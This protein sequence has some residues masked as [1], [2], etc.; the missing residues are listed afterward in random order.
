[1]SM[2]RTIFAVSAALVLTA[3]LGAQGVAQ[4]RSADMM[5]RTASA[6]TATAAYATG[7]NNSITVSW[8]SPTITADDTLVG[9]TI[10]SSPNTIGAGG[11][12]SR[13]IDDSTIRSF[14]FA[15]DSLTLGES[16]TF[17]VEPR[18]ENFPTA[19]QGPLSA[20]T[21]PLP[22]FQAPVRPTIGTAEAGNAAVNVRWTALADADDSL[23]GLPFARYT[24]TSIPGG[25]SCTTTVRTDD[26]C[27]VTG[28]TNGTS[29]TF[30]V[31]A[32]NTG[33]TSAPSLASAPV[34]PVATGRPSPPLNVV[35]SPGFEQASVSW[36]APSSQGT[37]G[38]TQYLVRSFN[39]NTNAADDT[40]S[41]SGI[42]P[43]TTCVV[44][45][46]TNSTPYYF[47][48]T[49]INASGSSLPSVPSAAVTPG[50]IVTPGAPTGVTAVAGVGAASVTWVAPSSTGGSAITGYTVT[51]N[52]G[53][54]TCTTT[55][56]LTCSVTGL[57]G[58]TSYTF[59]VTATNSSGTG[60]ASAA[61]NA[62]TPT[63]AIVPGAP[64]AVTATAGNASALVS[65]TAPLV[66]GSSA[67]TGYTVTS[68]STL[69]GTPVRTCTTTGATS[70]TVSNLTNGITYSFTVTATN[71]A[72]TG[73]ASAASNAVTPGSAVPSEPRSVTATA[74]DAAATVTWVAPTTP[75]SSAITGYTVTSTP[76]NRTCNTTGALTCT[77]TGLTNG[78]AYFFTVRALNSVGTGS[79]SLAS[80]IVTPRA[81][82]SRTIVIAGA[83]GEGSESN[84]VF[85]DGVT[86]GLVGQRVTPYFRFPGQSGFTAG[87]G[88]RTVDANGDFA[89]QRK[90]G[91]RIV[92]EFRAGEVRSNQ[93][94]ILAR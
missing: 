45:N 94:V 17:Q 27:V 26:S 65:W 30:T 18:T 10:Y 39:A 37:S 32:S 87:T 13:N 89:W 11:G 56:S 83:R 19:G 21:T 93:V 35:A 90:T 47:V 3:G 53:G 75:G 5:P 54:R 55:G 52:P 85:V 23:G 77:V 46:L 70:C 91:K 12:A 16:Y 80:N 71:A 60:P 9:F 58:G 67:I 50:A 1:M 2:K 78:E 31:T 49:A 66:I 7:V 25:F 92:V 82:E 42:P 6:V 28:L 74:G 88:T 44:T 14:N 40:C 51:S 34:T 64:T 38:I 20:P 41:V 4:A 84:L 8:T 43:A 33:A 24:A 36:T 29:Y 62:V 22:V 59:T 86:T 69:L 63:G 76:G 48:V 81:P 57:T 61:S 15:D 79:P 72:G 73:A 68:A